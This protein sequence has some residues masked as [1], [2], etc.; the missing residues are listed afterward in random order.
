MSSEEVDNFDESQSIVSAPQNDL[1]S[2]MS[3]PRKTSEHSKSNLRSVRSFA[4][5]VSPR[6]K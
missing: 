2:D 5:T 3:S 6:S 4:S 1:L